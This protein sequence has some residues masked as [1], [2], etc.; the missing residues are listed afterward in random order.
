MKRNMTARAAEIRR[1]LDAVRQM[2]ERHDALVQLA[3]DLIHTSRLAPVRIYLHC[4][5]C[6]RRRPL[7]TVRMTPGYGMVLRIPRL[8]IPKA[9]LTDKVTGERVDP[10]HYRERYGRRM[11]PLVATYPLSTHPLDPPRPDIVCPVHGP[12]GWTSE[13]L[14]VA[15]RRSNTKVNVTLT[16]YDGGTRNPS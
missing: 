9:E 10:E 1:F 11:H 12:L 4:S 13:E 7:A 16:P 2:E 3:E 14:L 6:A 8:T 15:A 5:R